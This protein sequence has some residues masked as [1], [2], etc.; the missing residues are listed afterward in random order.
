MKVESVEDLVIWIKARELV[1]SVYTITKKDKFK[2]DWIL[3]DQIRRA[4]ISVMSNISEG[5]ERGSN[6]EFI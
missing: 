5:F 6:A 1:N 4:A 3:V 2:R